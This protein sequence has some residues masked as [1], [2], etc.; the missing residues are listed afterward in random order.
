MRQEPDSPWI[1]CRGPFA[2]G[3]RPA[4]GTT[5]CNHINGHFARTMWENIYVDLGE[6]RPKDGEAI[7]LRHGTAHP[8]FCDGLAALEPF[9]RV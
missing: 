5:L 3:L 2:K 4:V 8:K 7:L 6:S 1:C 9:D